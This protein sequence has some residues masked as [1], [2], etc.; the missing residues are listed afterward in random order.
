MNK[1]CEGSLAN[2]AMGSMRLRHLDTSMLHDGSAP[3]KRQL[4]SCELR[5]AFAS[6]PASKIVQDLALPVFS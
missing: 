5:E 2:S 6:F 3:G 1:S 4:A